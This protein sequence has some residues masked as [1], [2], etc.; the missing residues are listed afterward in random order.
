MFDWF[1]KTL[2]INTFYLSLLKILKASNIYIRM[3]EFI[4]PREYVID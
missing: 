4:F 1:Y 2:P 3:L